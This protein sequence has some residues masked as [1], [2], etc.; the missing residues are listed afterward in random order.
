[1]A[2]FN[3]GIISNKQSLRIHAEQS[4]PL[5]DVPSFTAT[6]S[7]W[8]KIGQKLVWLH[9][10]VWVAVGP[11]IVTVSLFWWKTTGVRTHWVSKKPIT[12]HRNFFMTR[13]IQSWRLLVFV[14]L[15]NKSC[16][17]QN[18][19]SVVHLVWRRFVRAIEHLHSTCPLLPN[20]FRRLLWGNRC[21]LFCPR[22]PRC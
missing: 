6:F 7:K 20:D 13:A 3:F 14:K 5:A 22:W 11:H 16:W 9:N 18:P 21:C 12:I 1:M 19:Y 17:I 10:A 4:I 2:C 8:R 15:C